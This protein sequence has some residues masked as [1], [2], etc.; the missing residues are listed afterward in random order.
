[1][2]EELNSGHTESDRKIVL[3][4]HDAGFRPKST[5]HPEDFDFEELFKF[6]ELSSASGYSFST[7]DNY[8]TDSI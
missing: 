4:M 5:H 3:L 8:L 2:L 1:M 7:I 6:L